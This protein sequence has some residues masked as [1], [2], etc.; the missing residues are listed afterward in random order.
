MNSGY[1][2]VKTSEFYQLPD[3]EGENYFL[4]SDS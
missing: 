3:L 4:P 2:K 1:Y